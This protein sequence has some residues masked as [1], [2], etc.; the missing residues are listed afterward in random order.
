L[1]KSCIKTLEGHQFAV[2]SLLFIENS[3]KLISVD[4]GGILRLWN[5]KKGICEAV[6]EGHNEKIWSLRGLPNN[7]NIFDN[8]EV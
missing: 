2:L 7:F 1:D 4:G 6:E 8:I 3:L 5:I